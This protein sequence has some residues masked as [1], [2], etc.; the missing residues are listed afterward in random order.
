MIGSIDTERVKGNVTIDRSV[1][2]PGKKGDSTEESRRQDE[3][4]KLR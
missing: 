3:L 2:E 4:S 1:W